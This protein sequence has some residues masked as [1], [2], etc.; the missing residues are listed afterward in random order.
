MKSWLA[1]NSKRWLLVI[2]NADN[3]DSDYSELM[4]PG[5]RG[6]I[7]F[8]TRNPE[9]DRYHTVGSET[10]SGLE[11]DLAQELLLR[12]MYSAKSWSSKKKNAARAIVEL[13]E[14]H[15]LAII[16]AG[17]YI[18]QKK[19]TLEEYPDIFQQMKKKFLKFHSKQLVSTYGN[20]YMTFEVAAEYLQNSKKL[21]IL[22]A[23]HIFAFMHNIGISEAMFQRA[24]EYASELIDT[25]T[26]KD[27][28]EQLFSL[29]VHHVQRH[30]NMSGRGGLRVFYNGV[31]LVQS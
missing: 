15:T 27:R 11:P 8:T 24:S 7:L 30:Q 10:L 13:L 21:D 14:S 22:D 29:S 20:V 18:R 26:S 5:R 25:G 6:D 4:R 31:K 3:P 19:C 12:T 2:D 9:C 23:L 1:D 16:Q 28:E 17:A